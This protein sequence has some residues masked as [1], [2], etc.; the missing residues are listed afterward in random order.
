MRFD[1][2]TLFNIYFPNGKRSEE[3]LKYKMAFYNA[4]ASGFLPKER[5]WLDRVTAGGYVDVF[6]EF[7]QEPGQ[8][9]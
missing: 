1:T 7:N 4:N 9:T 5:K 8:Y 2:F 6:G 3:R